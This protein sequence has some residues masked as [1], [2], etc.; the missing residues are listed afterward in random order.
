MHWW[1]LPLQMGVLSQILWSHA[2]TNLFW[3]TA[4]LLDLSPGFPRTPG[5]YQEQLE[6]LPFLTTV[7]STSMGEFPPQLAVKTHVSWRLHH[8]TNLAIMAAG[9]EF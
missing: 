6:A 9:S 7:L 1:T 2:L 3:L 8:Q 5:L 4:L